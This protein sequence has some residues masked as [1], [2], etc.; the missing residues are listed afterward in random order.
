M[1]PLSVRA[2]EYWPDGVKTQSKSAIVMEVNTGTV[3][4]EKKSHEKHY[5]ASI[6]KI[7]TVL[8]A[9]ENCDMDEVV[10][11]SADA[12]FKNEGDTSHI[13]RNLG[14]K[15]T[16]EQCLYAVMLE[17]ANECAYAVAE[18][19]GQKLGGDYQTYI[20]SDEAIG[21]LWEQIQNDNDEKGS[22]NPFKD[23]VTNFQS[24]YDSSC[25][26]FRHGYG[27]NNK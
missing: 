21:K 2:D 18:H 20:A 26:L 7:M 10:T 15:L 9:I 5:P 11:F 27:D 17:S 24:G 12:V 4:Y 3:L 19:V 22:S 25:Q 23:V 1:L 6:T 8:L 16:M 13:A 14:E